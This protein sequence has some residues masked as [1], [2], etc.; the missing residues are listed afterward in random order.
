M[1]RLV[2]TLF[3]FAGL[4]MSV[5]GDVKFPYEFG[6]Y[7]EIKCRPFTPQEKRLAE[8]YVRILEVDGKPLKEPF[9]VMLESFRKFMLS[10]DTEYTASGYFSF[11]QYGSPYAPEDLPESRYMNHSQYFEMRPV[12]CITRI[13]SPAAEKAR[14]REEVLSPLFDIIRSTDPTW[15]EPTL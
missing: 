15:K 2:Q 6:S 14:F 5:F 9:L 1:I 7:H 10:A 13:V 3:F 11:K 8:L 12:F 4:T